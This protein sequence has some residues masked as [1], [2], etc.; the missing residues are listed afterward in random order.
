MAFDSLYEW[1]A[2]LTATVECFT[3]LLDR[4]LV[5]AET[6]S[7]RENFARAVRFCENAAVLAPDRA[8]CSQESIL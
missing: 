4:D 1:T 2:W 8:N 7:G 5:S 3:W 6:V